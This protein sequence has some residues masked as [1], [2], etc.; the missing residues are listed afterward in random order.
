MKNHR[1]ASVATVRAIESHTRGSLPAGELMRRAGAAAARHITDCLINGGHSTGH[2][3]VLVGPGD[4]GG[5][6]RIA[7]AA[8][9]QNG[10]TVDE[11]CG[12]GAQKLPDST[13]L[14]AIVDALFGFGL[15]RPII[16]E[17]IR[18]VQWINVA[19]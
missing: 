16:G 1:L 5:D 10:Y 11:I 15:S 2:I 17:W 6:G 7:A 13:D 19:P 18:A 14:I 12:N 4:N 9:R 8:L 3:V